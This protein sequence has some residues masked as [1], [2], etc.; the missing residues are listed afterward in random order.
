MPGVCDVYV[1]PREVLDD[2]REVRC[3]LYSNVEALHEPR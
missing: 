1:P 3:L 2:G